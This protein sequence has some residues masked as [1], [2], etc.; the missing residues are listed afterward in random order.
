M[1]TTFRAKEKLEPLRAYCNNCVPVATR[2]RR[3]SGQWGWK[4][5]LNKRTRMSGRQTFDV[6]V[7]GQFAE[8]PVPRG[9]DF[10]YHTEDKLRNRTR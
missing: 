4:P 5:Q 2:A 8:D 7:C 6:D 1:S 3:P 10:E 9:S